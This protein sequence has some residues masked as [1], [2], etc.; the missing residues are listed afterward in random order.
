MKFDAL[1]FI[2]PQGSGK[3]TQAKILAAKHNLF[4]WEMGAILREV[5]QEDSPL[6]NQ[7]RDLHDRGVLFPDDLLISI[8]KDRLSKIPAGQGVIFDGIPRRLGQ[9]QFLLDYLAGQQ[10]TEMATVFIDLPREESINRL[11]ARAKKE[12]RK[13]DTR[14]GIEF[15]LKQYE[16]D[17]V[18]VLDY[19]KQHSTFLAIDGRPPI[20][21][22]TIA[23]DKALEA[24][25]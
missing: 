16:N 7:A 23:I 14:E 6:G 24:Y 2:G 3:G 1:F 8:V 13:D 5:G 25:A 4:Y 10:R 9:A 17:T 22:V 18:P 11:L 12:N 20:E 19:L 15:R 21:E